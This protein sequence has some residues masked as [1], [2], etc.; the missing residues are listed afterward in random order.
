[1]KTKSLKNKKI[2]A[3]IEARMSSTRLPGKVLMKCLGKPMLELMIERVRR[4]K[5]IDEIVI[6]TTINPADD[7]IAKFAKKIKVSCFRGSEND[8]MGR[9]TEAIVNADADIVV[10]L[11]GDCPLI[12]PVIIDQ[13]IKRFSSGKYDLIGNSYISH[14]YPIGLDIKI[15]TSDVFR[16]AYSIA[17]DEPHHEHTLLSAVENPKEFRLLNIKAPKNLKR[18]AFR[19]T[20]DTIE[21]FKFISAVFEHFY[22]KNPQFT[23]LQIV[24]YLD[25]HPEIVEI[26]K[27]VQQK[28][29]R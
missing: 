8:V 25:S 16:K 2:I 12:D 20:L 15:T 27:D 21:D 19:W 14:T 9:V 6:A 24:K 4:S 17:V 7:V 18:P 10:Q 11:T 3:T 13:Y 1:M 5:Y 22:S 28:K 26:N 23:S 29:A